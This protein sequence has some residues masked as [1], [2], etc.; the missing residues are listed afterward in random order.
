MRLRL[1]RWASPI[2]TL[3]LVTDEADVL[4]ALWLGDRWTT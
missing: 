1:E 2:S 4:R 3:L